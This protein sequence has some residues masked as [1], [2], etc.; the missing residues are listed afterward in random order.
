MSESGTV[1]CSPVEAINGLLYFP[2]L[3]AK[4]RL[5]AQ[6][7]LREDLRPNLGKGM[8]YWCAQFLHINYEDLAKRV[9]KGGTDAEILQWCEKHGRELNDVD[10]LIWQ[11]FVLKLGIDDRATEVLATS[12]AKSGLAHRDDI[13]TMAHFIDVDEGRKP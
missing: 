12:K 7:R 13:K 2:R 6:S 4:I 8:D 11:N 9:L 5:N 1:P 3:T 10:K